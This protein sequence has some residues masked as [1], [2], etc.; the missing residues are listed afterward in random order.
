MSNIKNEVSDVLAFA[1]I[2]YLLMDV[3]K[4]DA[5]KLK[6]LDK[7]G[8][9]LREPKN[10]KEE[11]ALNSYVILIVKLKSLLG[12][13]VSELHKFLELQTYG[14][15]ST[16]SIINSLNRASTNLSALKKLDDILKNK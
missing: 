5:I 13:R 14:K 11:L 15:Q 10:E 3:N 12:G 2:N 4:L 8:N 6:L 7:N 9:I 1:L 16:D